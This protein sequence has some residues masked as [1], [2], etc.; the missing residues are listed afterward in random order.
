MPTSNKKILVTGGLGFIGSHFVEMLLKKDFSVINID[1]ITYASRKGLN[2]ERWPKYEFIQKDIADLDRLPENISHIVNFAAESHVDN[3]ILNYKP[4]FKSN[5]Q[6]VFNLLD[7]LTKT[8]PAKRPT[9]LHISTDEVYGDIENGYFKE[10]DK[11]NPSS[12]YS[13]TKAAADQLIIGWARTYG[14]K[15]KICRPS[16]NY[17]FG[18]KEEKLIPRT[19]KLAMKNQKIGLHG[20]GLY[21]REWTFVE[22]N[23]AAIFLVME[24]GGDNEI[25]NIS[26]HEELSNL[27]VVKKVLKVMDKPEDF[28][29]YVKDRPG[30]D[31]RYAVNTE[32]IEKLGW[33]PTTTLDQF[34]PI[35]RKLNEV[36]SQCMP[37]G[38][39]ARILKFLRLDKIFHAR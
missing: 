38:K 18:Q 36:R 15:Y 20:S 28:F 32:K 6:G 10:T 27:E 4:F 16:N 12:P 37:P 26:A 5:V 24:K 1:K 11:L 3:S 39:K 7:L 8:E 34:L 21:R 33:K 29:E 22:D 30:Q 31:V 17:G 35:C 2:F 23:C 25:Y 19:M 13:A 14:V 9:L